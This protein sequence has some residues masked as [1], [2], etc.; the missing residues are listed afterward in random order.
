MAEK[1]ITEKILEDYNDVFADIVNVCFFGGKQIIHENELV[2]ESP[3]SMYKAGGKIHE[4]ERDVAKFWKKNRIRVAIIGLENQTADDADMPL[5]VIGY[6]GASYRSQLLKD[7]DGKKSDDRFAV[8]T[9]VLYFGYKHRWNKPKN[10]LDVVSVPEELKPYVNDYHINVCE[11]A[12]LSDEQVAMFRSDFRIVADYFVQMRKNRK[13]GKRYHPSEERLRHINEVLKLLSVI[14]G[15]NS[16]EKAYNNVERRPTTMCEVVESFVQQG[17]E[18]GMQQ[19]MQQ[20]IKQGMQQGIQQGCEKTASKT[21]LR[22]AK[23]SIPIDLNVLTD[24]A[25][26][27]EL[28]VQKVREIAERNGVALSC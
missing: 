6:D 11:V 4:L 24:I 10:L 18:Q 26:D 5:R 23:R 19:G 25:D 21:L 7:E 28:S 27:T 14:T 2:A 3:H 16:Y 1:D 13:T 9:L 20:G 8:V 17:R 22:F 15:D 12:W